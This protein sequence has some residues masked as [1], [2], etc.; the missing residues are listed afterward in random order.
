MILEAYGNN[1]NE[2]KSTTEADITACITEMCSA[3]LKKSKG[4]KDINVFEK[5]AK[6]ALVFCCRQGKK[7]Q[8]PRFVQEQTKHDL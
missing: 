7:K 8:R 6:S 3:G 1:F 4:H 5:K 2:L